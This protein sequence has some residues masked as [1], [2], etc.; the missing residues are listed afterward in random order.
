VANPTK[1]PAKKIALW[2]PLENFVA[3]N[4]Y[5]GFADKNLVL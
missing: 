4:P 1:L 2:W 3:V 5:L